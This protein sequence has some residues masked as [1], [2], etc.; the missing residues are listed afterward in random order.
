[1]TT[2][3][4]DLEKILSDLIEAMH[5]YQMDVEE[6]P[7]YKHRVMMD[8]ARQ[9][10]TDLRTSLTPKPTKS[11][12]LVYVSDVE[13]MSIV[14]CCDTNESFCNVYTVLIRILTS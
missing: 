13:S 8:R 10:L 1:M 2:N 9:A 12:W 11:V 3:K 7:P 5:Q 14:C 6:D 4:E